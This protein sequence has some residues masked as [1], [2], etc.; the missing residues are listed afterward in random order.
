MAREMG[1][2]LFDRIGALMLKGDPAKYPSQSF[3]ELLSPPSTSRAID[4]ETGQRKWARNE[5]M[6]ALEGASIFRYAFGLVRTR[7]VPLCVVV[8]IDV[9]F[10][11]AH[12]SLGFYRV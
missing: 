1:H 9:A 10:C 11:P 7:R 2:E 8:C 12:I 5:L 4:M 6:Y 3:H